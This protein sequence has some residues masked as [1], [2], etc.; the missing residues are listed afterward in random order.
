MFL[1]NLW[2]FAA[3][4][5]SV[6]PGSMRHK[7]LLGEPILIGRTH[8]G[9]VF[10]IRDVCPHRGMLLSAGKL[11]KSHNG[12]ASEVECP[13]HGWR[14]RTDGA[15]SHIPSLVD[16][17]EF[18]LERIRVR[19]Y[20]CREQ[21]HNIWVYMPADE[22]VIEQPSE[23]PPVIPEIGDRR[24]AFRESEVFHCE[25]DHAIVGLMDPA[26]GPFVHGIWWWRPKFSIHEKEKAFSPSHLGFTMRAHE[27]SRNSFLYRILGRDVST[28]IRFQLPGVRIEHVRAARASVIGL[29]TV[30]AIDDTKTEVTQTFYWTQPLFNVVKPIFRPMARAF[31][32][33]DRDIVDL[34]QKALPHMKKQILI[35]DADTPAKWYY[36]LKENWTTSVDTGEPFVNPVTDAV[37]RWRS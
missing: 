23:D 19:C 28:E 36:R 14:Y 27:P 24:P 9:E 35:D 20:P 3:P 26:H 17:Q 2:Y 30:V 16:G 34:Q 33:Q 11:L 5:E 12:Q 4:G 15:C 7:T 37:L 25:I 10:A 31:L 22:R 32:R 1:R 6:R 21:Q 13:Y 8:Q 18:E 29:T